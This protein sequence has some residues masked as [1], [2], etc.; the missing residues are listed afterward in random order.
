MPSRIK[1]KVN[2]KGRI[3]LLQPIEKDYKQL[4][5]VSYSRKIAFLK[6]EDEAS[7]C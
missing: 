4:V 6:D 1:G 3:L 2:E 5:R 7:T